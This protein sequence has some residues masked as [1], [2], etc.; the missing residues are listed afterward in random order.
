MGHDIAAIVRVVRD[1]PDLFIVDG[2]S[3][4]GA[5]ECRTDDWAIDVLV[6]GSQ[7]ALMTPPGLAFLSVSPNAW[8][9]IE[10]IDRPAFYFDLLAYARSLA[11]ERDRPAPAARNCKPWFGP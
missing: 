3:G 4:V 9:R 6:V 7:N 5:M 11:A 2:I 8:R 1:T 10:A